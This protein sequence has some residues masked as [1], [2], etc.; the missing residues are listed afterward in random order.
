MNVFISPE[1]YLFYFDLAYFNIILEQIG[2]VV[3][4]G[5]TVNHVII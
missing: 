1:T 4:I 3:A 5:F 2:T